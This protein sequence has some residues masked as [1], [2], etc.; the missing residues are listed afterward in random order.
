[1]T[2]PFDNSYAQLPERFYEKQNPANA[3]DPQLLRV[4]TALAKELGLDP[5]WLEGPNGLALFSGN[6]VP[7]G[8]TPLAQA[9]SGHQYGNF[10][11]MLGDG[12][13]LLLGEILTPKGKRFDLQLK[14]SGRTPFSRGG[15]GKSALGPVLREYLVSEAMHA[16]GI[17]STRALAAVSSGENVF[18]QDG[19]VPGGIFT[20][21]AASHI[22]VGTF[23]YF[24][25]RKDDEALMLLA[26]HVIARHY[27][28]ADSYIGLL[29]A[30]ISAQAGLI[31]QW[32]SVG[33][34]HGVMNT[35]NCAISGETID[36]GPC[37]FMDD[38]HPERVFSS[39]D[40]NGRYAWGNQP[41][42]AHWNLTRFAE[43]LLPLIDPNEEKAVASAEE[44]L[45]KFASQF[46]KHYLSRFRAKLALPSD[47]DAEFIDNTLDLL[48]SQKLDFTIF[49][50]QLTLVAAGGSDEK[51]LALAS[52]KEPLKI[53]F[54][55]WQSLAEP[56]THL[57]EMKHANPIRIPR[58]H[59]IEEAIQAAYKDDFT[60]FHRLAGAWI[61][62]FEENDDLADLET[63]PLP[64]EVVEKTF[65]GT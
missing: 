8:A 60:L 9:Y 48:A 13:A 27:P 2:L 23:Q 3:P 33:F 5:T 51:L 15:D 42:I 62:P 14:G 21:I 37:A 18:R 6:G 17:P 11:P 40:R 47:S 31:A 44:S 55:K 56:E 16:M 46:Q 64:K 63:P 41:V 34:I 28:E 61:T 30:V 24:L 52:D 35:D 57:S 53:W 20:R 19:M 25:A 49:F 22:R 59:R 29:D 58:N 1:M 65:C 10:S 26:D 4:N 54:K 50:R 39:I 12:R 32:M 36:F 7:A 38:F 45:K 43:T